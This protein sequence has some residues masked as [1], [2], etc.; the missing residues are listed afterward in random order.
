MTYKKAVKLE[1]VNNPD[2]VLVAH[3]KR[4]LIGGQS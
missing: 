2:H 4:M 1:Q 3:L